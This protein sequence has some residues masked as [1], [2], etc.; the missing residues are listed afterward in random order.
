MN[1]KNEECKKPVLSSFSRDPET[2]SDG[3]A[4]CASK[5]K[6]AFVREK[7]SRKSWKI[8]KLAWN[9]QQKPSSYL[10]FVETRACDRE[11]NDWAKSA[12]LLA[13]NKR[14]QVFLVLLLAK[15]TNHSLTWKFFLLLVVCILMACFIIVTMLIHILRGRRTNHTSGAALNLRNDISLQGCFMTHYL[16]SKKEKSSNRPQG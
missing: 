8:H 7:Y 15:L 10:A 9:G 14:I 6:D 16:S 13:A 11:K 4:S 2:W 1:T 3:L 12:D 5:W